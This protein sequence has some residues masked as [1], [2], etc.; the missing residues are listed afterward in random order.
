ML[1]LPTELVS[2]ATISGDLRTSVPSSDSIL[3]SDVL[4]DCKALSPVRKYAIG[5][6]RVFCS[7]DTLPTASGITPA[8]T[9]LTK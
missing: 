8:A 1:K 4:R 9:V 3:K 6:R 5:P 7:I 2:I